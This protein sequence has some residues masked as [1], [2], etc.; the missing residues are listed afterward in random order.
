M[1]QVFL[2]DGWGRSGFAVVVPARDEAEHLARTLASFDADPAVADVL[3]VA[4]GCRDDTAGLARRWGGRLRVGVVETGALPGGVGEVRRLG[5]A[6]A[7]G[8]LPADGIL[9]TTDA[10]CTL[11]PDWGAQTRRALMGADAVCGR[12]APEADGFAGLPPLIRRHGQLEDGLRD[13]RAVQRAGLA[14]WPGRP[15]PVH[16]CSAGA[17][18]AFTARCYRA[19]G[20]FDPVPCHEDRA[21]IARIEQLGFRVARPH[22]LTIRASCRLVGRAPEGMAATIAERRADAAPLRAEI[23]LLAGEWTRRAACAAA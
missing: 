12:L 5:M 10:D 2:P 21:L 16:G 6:V 3:I 7:L 20:G 19:A 22:A 11:G 9:A 17:S 15:L 13:L 1:T 4:N 18:L 23:D 8:R 14:W